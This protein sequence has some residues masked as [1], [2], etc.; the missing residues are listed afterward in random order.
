MTFAAELKA[1]FEKYDV[2]FD[3]KNEYSVEFIA[4]DDFSN[5]VYLSMDTESEFWTPAAD[6]MVCYKKGIVECGD[7]I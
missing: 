6:A 7:Q 2:K 5:T 4:G 1:L 3:V